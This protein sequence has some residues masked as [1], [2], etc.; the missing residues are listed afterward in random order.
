M[1]EEQITLV[2]IVSSSGCHILTLI[3]SQRSKT[4][5]MEVVFFLHSGSL[6]A[7]SC[8]SFMMTQKVNHMLDQL[9]PL[10]QV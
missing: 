2:Q 1:E 9:G 6:V 4:E 3:N 10:L 7:A 8:I 5:I